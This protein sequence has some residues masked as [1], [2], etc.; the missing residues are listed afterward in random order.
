VSELLDAAFEKQWSES[1]LSLHGEWIGLLLSTYYDPMYDYQ[2]EKRAGEIL[3][4]GSRDQ[5]VANALAMG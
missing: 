3:F 5:V 4:S 1:D 2:L